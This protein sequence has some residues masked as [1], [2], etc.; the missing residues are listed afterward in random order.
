MIKKTMF[1]NKKSKSNKKVRRVFKV[2]KQNYKYN[3]IRKKISVKYIKFLK[4]NE[5]K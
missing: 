4:K 1:G 5:K 3:S 2:N